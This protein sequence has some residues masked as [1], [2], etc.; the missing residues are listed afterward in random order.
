MTEQ[1][2]TTTAE[3]FMLTSSAFATSAGLNA[4]L[5]SA[6]VK[7]FGSMSNVAT[8]GEADAGK[9]SYKYMTLGAI[10]QAVRHPLSENGL[11]LMQAPAIDR[12]GANVDVS[13]T[14]RLLHETGQFMEATVS[15]SVDS[16]ADAQSIG[17]AMTYARRY[18]LTALLG[19]ASGDDDDGAAASRQSPQ[20]SGAYNEQ[21]AKDLTKVEAQY[22]I[23]QEIVG[24]DAN[25]ATDEQR[26]QAREFWSE[27]NHDSEGP[28]ASASIGSQCK[29][30]PD[31]LRL[32]A[33][34]SSERETH[35]ETS[36]TAE[37]VSNRALD[38]ESAPLRTP[39]DDLKREQ[40][41]SEL[42]S[43]GEPI[44]GLVPELRERLTEARAARD[45]IEAAAEFG[46]ELSVGEAQ[47]SL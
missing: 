43:L 46:A 47:D 7:A 30:V 40:L 3:A 1:D 20:S 31:W 16:R 5:C 9:Y 8:D 42:E 23:L 2:S 44:N 28:F 33:L 35:V 19:I 6:F 45:L 4:E 12:R 18:G 22:A 29:L 24:G 27:L 36:N 25:A 13:V 21:A 34:T 17:S 32:R 41:V 39:V 38:E 10:M 15:M 14:T 26:Q 11:A 37:I